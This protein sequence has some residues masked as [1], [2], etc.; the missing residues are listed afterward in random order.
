MKNVIN[1]LI[2]FM[3]LGLSVSHANDITYP[4]R[5]YYLDQKGYTDV[6]YDINSNGKVENVRVVK[7]EPKNIFENSVKEQMHRWKFESGHP[8]KDVKLRIDFDK[9]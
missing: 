5:A 3:L 7:A 2:C 8:Q 6:I 1:L 4:K 9:K